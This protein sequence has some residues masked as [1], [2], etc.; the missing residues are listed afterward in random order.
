MKTFFIAFLTIICSIAASAQQKSPGSDS[1]DVI[2]YSINID[3]VNI[4]GQQIYGYTDVYFQPKVNNLQ[5]IPLDLLEL[6]VDSV[7]LESALNTTWTYNDTLLMIQ[8]PVPMAIN[9]TLH[10]KIYY[11]GHPV[12]D[13]SGWGGFYFQSPYAYNLGVGFEDNPHNYGRVWFPCIDDFTDKA[14]Y[15]LYVLTDTNQM[16]VCGGMLQDTT[17]LESGDLIAWHWVM[18]EP[19]PTYIVSIAVGPYVCVTDT[20]AGVNGNIP[21]DIYVASSYVAKVPGTFVN[22]K[23][24]L[25]A[26]ENRFGPYMWERVGYVGVPFNAGAMEHA[27]NIAL[28]NASITGNTANESLCAHELSHHWFGD[29]VTCATPEEMWINEGWAVFSEFIMKESIYG[30][31]AMQE[32]IRNVHASVLR[33]AHVDDGGFYPVGNVPHNITYGTTVY[34]KGALVAH[35]LRNYIGDS[36]FFPALKVYFDSLKY[37]NASNNQLRDIL[38]DETGIDLTDFFDAWV[39][40]EGF[41]HFDV[42]SMHVA[43]AGA[44]S[45]VTVYLRQKLY[46]TTQFANSNRVELTFMDSLWNTH[47]VTASFSGQSGTDVFTVP[48]A[49]SVVIVDMDEKTA[50][51]IVSYNKIITAPSTAVFNY[52]FVD[53]VVNSLSDSIF[54]RAEH[55]KAAPDPL[56]SNPE[57]FRLSQSRYWRVTG[58]IPEETDYQL[59]FDYNRTSNFYDIELLPDNDCVDSLVLVY[60]PGPGFDWQIF[61]F[62][63]SGNDYAGMLTTA[64]GRTGEYA[65]AV[66]EPFQSG[67]SENEGTLKLKLFPNPCSGLLQIENIPESCA[68]LI[69]RDFNG[70]L[71]LRQSVPNDAASASIDIRS[72]A[73]GEYLVSSI[74]HDGKVE[75]CSTLTVIG[76]K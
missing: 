49:P 20:F 1:I 34:D 33:T 73:A 3:T 71:L 48:F 2:R 63:K 54:V 4:A 59:K 29:L 41:P 46:G 50:D 37:G 69:I 45:T 26:Y 72:L 35:T 75:S 64:Y 21:I 8:S 17:H 43:P 51:A 66:G 67:V 55:H 56:V 27:M 42:D 19:V 10:L 74:S 31:P 32:Y 70:K 47:T 38:S 18:S 5:F 14:L 36:L 9:D 44:N 60:R 12:I 65:L 62:T 28:P 52:A 61:P 58:M 25:T 16:A 11:H 30:V 53:I 6:I 57:I 40:R 39:L 24:I 22:L 76:A 68:E 23:N 13:P 7:F 15:E